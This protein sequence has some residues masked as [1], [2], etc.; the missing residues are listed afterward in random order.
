MLSPS[1]SV[2]G[3]EPHDTIC[4]WEH[5][6]AAVLTT[7]GSSWGVPGVVKVG[8]YQ[9]GYTGTLDPSISDLSIISQ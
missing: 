3:L 6:R 2:D 8:G 5:D 4:S 7:P 9:E 1:E